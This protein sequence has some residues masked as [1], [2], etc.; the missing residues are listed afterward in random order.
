[1]IWQR[2]DDLFARDKSGL[3][4]KAVEECVDGDFQKYCVEPGSYTRK[5][6]FWKISELLALVNHL[7][8]DQIRKIAAGGHDTK[9][10]YTAYN[11]RPNTK[12]SDGDSREN[13][14]RLRLGEAGEGRNISHQ[15]KKMNERSCANSRTLRDSCHDDR[16]CRN[17]VL[18]SSGRQPGNKYLLE[19]R[20]RARRIFAARN[21]QERQADVPKLDYSPN[22]S[23]NP[24]R[25]FR[26]HSV[27]KYIRVLLRHKGVSKNLVPIIPEEARTF[28]R[29]VVP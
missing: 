16:D 10:V 12:A 3:L 27:W 4:L 18:S 26:Q 15:Q 13:G 9:K 24:R 29:R 5:H 11:P 1:V 6:F 19:R 20:K 8:D 28:T 17:A 7:T 23:R 25:K 14:Q 21:R 2:L 22:F